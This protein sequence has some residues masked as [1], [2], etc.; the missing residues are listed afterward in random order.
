MEE[1][2]IKEF[3][4]ITFFCVTGISFLLF[5]GILKF[6]NGANSDLFFRVGFFGIG[7]GVLAILNNWLGKKIL[8]NQRGIPSEQKRELL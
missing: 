3:S 7:L 8:T 2:E 1:N 4:W 6:L 5:G